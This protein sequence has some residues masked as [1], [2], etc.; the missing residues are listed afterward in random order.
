MDMRL[1]ED[2]PALQNGKEN[3]EYRILGEIHGQYEDMVNILRI[4]EN[5]EAKGE[6]KHLFLGDY[7]DRG[8]HSFEV[9]LALFCWKILYPDRVY[10]LRGNHEISSIN[11][12]YG[13][14]EELVEIYGEEDGKLVHSYFNSVFQ[15]MPVAAVL[16]QKYF[17]VHGGLSKRLTNVDSLNDLKFPITVGPAGKCMINDMLWADPSQDDDV[18]YFLENVKR[19]PIYGS[20]AVEEF[21]QANNLE[22]VIRAHQVANE[23]YWTACNEKL[24]NVF[25][26]PNYRRKNKAAVISV[27]SCTEQVVIFEKVNGQIRACS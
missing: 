24:I 15:Y 27:T 26:A 13:F 5:E 18:K 9:C 16:H 1:N 2:G 14:L 25:S 17:C 12:K 4:T 6:V 19:G 23:G 7:V 22:K 8:T 11:S 10:L 3:E 21:C 20:F